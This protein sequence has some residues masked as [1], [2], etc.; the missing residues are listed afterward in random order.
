[1]N[2]AWAMTGA[3]HYLKESVEAVKQIIEEGNEVTLFL[4]AA[5][6]VVL[7]SYNLLQDV[8]QLKVK[9]IFDEENQKPAFHVSEYFNLHRY[10]LLII[11]PITSNSVGKMSH[12]I[13]DTLVTNIFAQMIKGG[14]K[15]MC[16]PSDVVAGKIETIAPGGQK[17]KIHIDEF[18]SQNAKNLAK[19]PG[20]QVFETP[21][22]ILLNYE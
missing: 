15:I 6:R 22:Q 10:D 9:K 13:A 14:G 5:A 18:N 2:I 12:G 16:M 8:I 7:K 11:S 1:M 3:G 19:F 4:S 21:A 17:V 20:V